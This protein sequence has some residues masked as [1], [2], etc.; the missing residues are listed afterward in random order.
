[1]TS[2]RHGAIPE[3]YNEESKS[4]DAF[5]ETNS[6]QT[7]SVIE[8]IL[9][10]YNVKSVL[11]LTCGTGSQ[12]FWLAKQGYQITGSDISS[13]MLN[14]A[15]AKAKKEKL[16]VPLL[17]G[18][19]RTIKVGTF[20]AALTIFNA[21]GHLTKVGFEKAM[22]NVHANLNDGGI[23]V[24]DIFNAS[25][26]LHDDNIVKLSIEWIKNVGTSKLRQ[27]QHSVIDAKGLLVS[28][29]T[30]YEHQVSGKIKTSKSVGTLQTYTA[31][32]LQDMLVRNGFKVLGQ[33][34]IDGS[35]FL[36]KETERILVVAKKI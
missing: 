30:Y 2:I 22:R 19:M 11:D 9:K 21:V 3:W 18:D 8:K 15:K 36:E 7:N 31:K 28:Y 32:E 25:Y 1:M 33:H 26:L 23:Y 10:K 24:F 5:N 6:Q 20:D 12:V 27:I 17:L 29:T 34:A 13:G 16:N 35:K 4:Y 14:V